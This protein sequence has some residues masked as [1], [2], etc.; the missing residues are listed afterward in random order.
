MKTNT[1]INTVWFGTLAAVLFVLASGVPADAQSPKKVT[2]PPQSAVVALVNGVALT[3]ND[4]LPA[5]V[6]PAATDPTIDL[7]TL[8]A[9][10]QRAIDRQLILQTATNLNVY[11]TA[12][13]QAALTGLRAAISSSAP[14]AGQAGPGTQATLALQTNFQ[15]KDATAQYLLMTLLPVQTPAPGAP[16]VDRAAQVQQYLQQLRASA[17]TV[18]YQF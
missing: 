1:N 10:R 17:I 12:A 7:A 15:V 14:Y 6:G 18:L 8:Q 9:L 5:T 13:Q 2:R 16:P 11:L 3:M 4:V